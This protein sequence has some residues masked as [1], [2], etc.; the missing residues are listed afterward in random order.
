MN[1]W[2]P[3]DGVLPELR[4][5]WAAS[6]CVV[7][8][9]APG[10]GKTTRV[11][12]A[13]LTEG[14]GEV[15]VLEPR[16]LAA[17][18]AARRVAA[19]M[20]ERLGETVGYQ[21]R[22]EDVS[23]PG[24]R[25]RFL[26]E[27]VLTRRLLGDSALAGVG[28]VVLDEFH[29]RHLDG[30]LALA[31]LLRLQRSTRP[32][33]RIVVMSATLEALPL[34]AHLGGCPVVRCEGRL[35]ETDW[36]WTPSSP[37]TV[38][39]QVAAA[40]SGLARQTLPGDILVFLP[41]AREIRRAMELAEPVLRKQGWLGVA[42]YGDLSAEE[43]DRAVTPAA[44]ERKVIFSTN[45]AESSVTI[46][47]VRVVI[48]SGLARVPQDSPWTGLPSVEVKRISQASA[49]QRAGRAS[50]TG[51]G[52]VI[53]L[54]PEEDFVRRPAQDTPEIL[55]RELSQVVLDVR[56]LRT[57]VEELPW[58]DAPPAAA[59]EAAQALLDRLG[60]AGE[61]G[62]QMARLPLHPRLARMALE[63]ARLGGL[64]E[65][66]AA[67]ARISGGASEHEA[68]RVAGQIE[69][70][71][72]VPRPPRAD[73]HAVEKATL[74]AFPDRVAKRHRDAE[75]LLAGGGSAVLAGRP[76]QVPAWLVAVD[77][78]HR[79]ERGLPVVREWVAIESD[80]LIEYFAGAIE[81]R[82]ELVWNRDAE[83]VEE[84]T[85]LRYG[86]LV[87]EE[88]RA[89]PAGD[90]SG[91]LVE[92][93]MGALHRFADPAALEALLARARFAGGE[94]EVD[95]GACLRELAAGCVSFAELAMTAGE[96]GLL[97]S[98][99]A[100]LGT[101]APEWLTL[102]GGRRA[103]VHYEDGKP[104]WVASRLQDFFGMKE[105]PRV[106]GVTVVCHLLAPN[107]RPVQIT[108][109]LAGFW[110][111]HYPEIR[112]E[113]SRRYPRHAWPEKPD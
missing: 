106:A 91:L 70:L 71:V 24:T 113:L 80:W 78:E 79:R 75:V 32:D 12:P 30:D 18:L 109:D 2:L 102:P 57:A 25:I 49:R 20:G 33:L 64:R 26:T 7:L 58:L 22:F 19:E 1:G 65:G 97:R 16:R 17:R 98:L 112:R 14:G 86:G 93:A 27:G 105:S 74:A 88:T 83:R 55:R 38:E 21:V 72:R 48:D 108:S 34:A 29:E 13:L 9:A 89:R 47:G 99:E 63:A 61:L 103:R 51:P 77:V 31:L 42:L 36:R 69:R 95:V 59:V 90:V 43:Q 73:P 5:A 56:A 3:I 4:A 104:P 92:K 37:L 10:A 82:R 39:E 76:A 84:V 53:R 60:A 44:G 101:L 6:R 41:G 100:R 8:E 50:R 81:D 46:E 23:G 87:M 52:M 111:R 62:R 66:A 67:A 54:Y 35:F 94:A 15:W 85:S 11:P 45:I 110:Q 107:Q 28:T 40:L 96:G 68:W